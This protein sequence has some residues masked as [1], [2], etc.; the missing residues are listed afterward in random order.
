MVLI[1]V[2]YR[3]FAK[4]PARRRVSVR[5]LPAVAELLVWDEIHPL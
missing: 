3:V 4:A 5:G 1:C 2:P